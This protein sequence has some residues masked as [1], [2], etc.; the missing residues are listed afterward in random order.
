MVTITR[1]NFIACFIHAL[2]LLFKNADFIFV[3]K[4][5]LDVYQSVPLNIIYDFEVFKDVLLHELGVSSMI[6]RI[7][8]MKI[9]NDQHS[10]QHILSG[11][12]PYVSFGS[13]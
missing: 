3:H 7:R 13:H 10:V 2:V 6:H 5:V 1:I 4:Q 8:L 12:D 11:T 9:V